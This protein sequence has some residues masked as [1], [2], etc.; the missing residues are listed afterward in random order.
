VTVISGVGHFHTHTLHFSATKKDGVT[1]AV[2]PLLD[3]FHWEELQT[4]AFDSTTTN[5]VADTTAKTDGA[6]TGTLT[7]SPGDT[8]DW[9]CEIDNPASN[10]VTLTFRNEVQT[11]EMCIFGA[12]VVADTGTTQG[13]FCPRN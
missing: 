13:Y 11:G 6:H 1:G 3:M 9:S 7:L 2:T 5:P 10:T 12:Q 8:V 4:Y